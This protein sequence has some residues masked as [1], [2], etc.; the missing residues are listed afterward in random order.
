MSRRLPPAELQ[1]AQRWRG[2]KI[3]DT[4]TNEL[5]LVIGA[6]QDSTDQVIYLLC[7]FPSTPET[8]AVSLEKRPDL[9]CLVPGYARAR[10]R[11]S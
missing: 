4:K 5:G 10:Y 9:E 6:E 3:V 2:Q 7:R 11:L 8:V 1:Y